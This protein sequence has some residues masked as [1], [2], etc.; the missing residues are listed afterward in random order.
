MEVDGIKS[1]NLNSYEWV[2]KK[3]KKRERGQRG[4]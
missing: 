1:K 3:R 4:K 2:E